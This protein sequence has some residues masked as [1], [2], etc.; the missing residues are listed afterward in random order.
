M[1]STAKPGNVDGMMDAAAAI[2][3]LNPQDVRTGTPR[4]EI[5]EAWGALVFALWRVSDATTSEIGKA[6]GGVDHSRVIVVRDR[7]EERM[8]TDALFR[9]GISKLVEELRV[10]QF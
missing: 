9:L 2:L 3:G 5:R 1:T 7:V 6:L 10:A 8:K 4:P